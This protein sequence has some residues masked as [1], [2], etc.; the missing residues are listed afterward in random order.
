MMDGLF[1]SQLSL[2]LEIRHKSKENELINICTTGS[3]TLCT[4]VNLSSQGHS[5]VKVK[6]HKNQVNFYGPR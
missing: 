4:V 2:P 5:K 3:Q 6:Y 1:D